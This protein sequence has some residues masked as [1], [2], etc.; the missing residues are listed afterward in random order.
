VPRI[1]RYFSQ[2]SVAATPLPRVSPEAM[3][4]GIRAASAFAQEAQ[5]ASAYFAARLTE[6]RRKSELMRA[7]NSWRQGVNDFVLGLEG[8]TDYDTYETR[9]EAFQKKLYGTI[10]KNYKGDIQ[11]FD[12]FTEREL[13]GTRF[14]I[15]R[16]ARKGLIRQMEGQYWEDLAM[17][18][19]R[20][21]RDFIEEST[22]TAIENGYLD[23]VAG[24][25]AK[26]QALKK[27]DIQE[28]WNDVMASESHAEALKIIKATHL[29]PSE[30]SS[31][32]A[33]YDREMA[34]REAQEKEVREAEITEVQDDFITRAYD[35]S[36]P[37]TH[38]EVDNSILEPTGGG[39]KAFFHD[40]IEKR[41]K[42]IQKGEREPYTE[43]D[44][45]VLAKV[46]LRENDLNQP[47]MSATEILDLVGEGLGVKTAQSLIKTMSVRNTDIFKQTEAAL[48]A[49]FGFEGLLKGFGA[50]PLGA[51]YYNK[52][53]TDILAELTAKP[54]K[55]KELR[56]RMYE[57]AQPY[58]EQYWE[59]SDKDPEYVDKTLEL[60]GLKPSPM[61]KMLLKKAPP[62][63]YDLEYV[64]G[65]GWVK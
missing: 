48:K 52:A 44:P 7:Q 38:S 2:E 41:V 36:N 27:I 3:T 20:G 13:I 24:E 43:T 28:A 45:R 55:G 51:V 61:G 54:L 35:S 22:D 21:D 10:K 16:A 42:A 26:A 30:K 49:Q 23:P 33:A 50:K 47:P 12:N 18:T 37:L 8:D 19:K 6:A 9:F 53:M 65:K 58:L 46:L 32:V 29:S 56:D 40:L 57:L 64:P 63:D 11:D 4:Q 5:Q 59:A 1:P 14:E 60:M 39:S 15:G 34:F 31:L 25:K 62:K 17:A